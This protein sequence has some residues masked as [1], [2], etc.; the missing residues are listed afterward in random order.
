[1]LFTVKS[2]LIFLA[3]DQLVSAFFP[4]YLQEK[5]TGYRAS[6]ACE[7]NMRSVRRIPGMEEEKALDKAEEKWSG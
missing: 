2:M 5:I 7:R 3:D 1:M 6:P 4:L